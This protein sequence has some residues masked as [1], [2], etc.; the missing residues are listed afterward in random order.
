MLFSHYRVRYM[1]I[2][3]HAK[4]TF[5]SLIVPLFKLLFYVN[6]H[7]I[8]QFGCNFKHFRKTKGKLE[9]KKKS[10][11]FVNGL[12]SEALLVISLDHQMSA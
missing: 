2:I 6:F 3:H 9:K 7:V 5:F 12:H 1:Y 4:V 10:T 8:N 11:T